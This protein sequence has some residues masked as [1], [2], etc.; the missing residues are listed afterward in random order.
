MNNLAIKSFRIKNYKAIQDSG[1]VELM[2]LTVFI[3]NN[4]SGK[5]SFIEGLETY[6]TIIKQGLDTAMNRWRG[7]EHLR[8]KMNSHE[9]ETS[10]DG[11]YES[12]PMEFELCRNMND[13]TFCADM[14]VTLD[15]E[16]ELLIQNEKLA[17]SKILMVER[18]ANN[19]FYFPE[20]D[21]FDFS[22]PAS[23]EFSILSKANS[24]LWAALSRYIKSMGDSFSTTKLMQWLD[25]VNK[26]KQFWDSFDWQFIALNPDNML[27]PIRQKRISR[28]VQLNKDGSNIAKYL[29]SIRKLNPVVFNGIL[30]TLQHI[31]PYAQNLQVVLSTELE[32]NVYMELTEGE[33]KIADWLLSTGTLRIV[34]LLALLRH[35]NPPPLVVIEEI[36]NGLDPRTIRLMVEEICKIVKTGKT[37]IILTTHS[38]Y[39]LDLLQPE[40][41]VLVER[42]ITGQPTFNKVDEQSKLRKWAKDFMPT[43][44]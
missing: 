43:N 13:S 5:S 4:G 33:C 1:I 22:A 37:Q 39:F 44:N 30:E 26:N 8:N 35:P 42:A 32:R 29:L 16:K 24:A 10:E 15:K 41:V 6:Q 7:F 19:A 34:A 31:L 23:N 12:N 9:L 3:G 40:Q 18:K 25:D 28:E 27:A 20:V 36:E 38:P 17:F 21:S 11:T 2:P 14:A